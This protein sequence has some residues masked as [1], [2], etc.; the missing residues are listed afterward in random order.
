MRYREKRGRTTEKIRNTNKR[1]RENKGGAERE[2]VRKRYENREGESEK[3]ER[4]V[5]DSEIVRK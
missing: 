4:S 1:E 2:K 5:A 3:G